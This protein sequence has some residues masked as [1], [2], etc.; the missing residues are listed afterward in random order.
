MFASYFHISLMC[1]HFGM[2]NILSCRYLRLHQRQISFHVELFQFKDDMKYSKHLMIINAAF[3]ISISR[4]YEYELHE[5]VCEQ[6]NG[7]ILFIYHITL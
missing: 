6:R 1:R 2:L 4:N 5:D 3:C 7:K